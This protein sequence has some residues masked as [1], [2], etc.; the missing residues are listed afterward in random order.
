MVGISADSRD[1]S[2]QVRQ[3][4][5]RRL[6]FKILRY[7]GIPLFFR[8]VIHRHHVTVL[9]FHDM[10]KDKAEAILGYL[11]S[12]Y[13]VIS[14]GSFVERCRS[15]ENDLPPKSLIVT[16]DDGH[17]GNYELLPLV[18]RRK[19][20]V[21]VFLCGGLV[22][23]QRHFWCRECPPYH[24]AVR[25]AGLPNAERLR[26]LRLAGFIQERQYDEPQALTKAHIEEMKPYFD[27]QAHTLFHPSLPRCDD[28]EAR[29]E[30]FECRRILEEEFALK[31]DAISYPHGAYSDREIGLCRQGGYRCGVTADYGFN[32]TAS[33]L[34]RLK[35]ICLDDTVGIDELAV[36]ASGLWGFIRT[37]KE[38]V[39]G[40][41]R[42]IAEGGRADRPVRRRRQRRDDD[43][44]E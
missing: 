32:T 34:F 28:R 41:H 36:K 22:D 39:H 17:I 20:A 12:H 40:R 21:T 19:L 33:D 14:L 37:L 30:I 10:P 9:L 44:D 35:R 42:A 4:P 18:R 25:L 6:A 13:N 43:A 16:F 27:F 23:T 7:S 29:H 8:E 24:S 31:V 15:G 1:C 5:W 38:R 2:R 3:T 11:Q 26:L